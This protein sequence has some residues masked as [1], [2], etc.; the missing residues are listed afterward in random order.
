MS[1][2]NRKINLDRLYE[3]ADEFQTKHSQVT[4]SLS[5]FL[6]ASNLPDLKPGD[7]EPL[8][9]I[10]EGDITALGVIISE[11]LDFLSKLQA[12][13]AVVELPENGTSGDIEHNL[14]NL[15]MDQ[16]VPEVGFV[17]AREVL[18]D[19]LIKLEKY[20]VL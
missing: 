7:L 14:T 18:Y 15:I 13:A 8:A 12:Y 17:A 10:L 6:R 5:L 4:D 2:D 9:V 1:T 16:L 3:L 11:A 19:T 20:Y